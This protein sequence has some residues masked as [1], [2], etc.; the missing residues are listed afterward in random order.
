MTDLLD[1]PP[2]AGERPR[3]DP[4]IAQ[5][6]I[7]ARREEGRRRLQ[8]VLVAAAVVAC[9]GLAFGSLYTPL[10]QV[11]HVRITV[12][13]GSFP[14]RTVSRLSG[15]TSRTPTLDVDSR[16]VAARLDA[17]PSLGAARVAR[18]W[19]GTV[20]I[21]VVVRSPLAVVASRSGY[22][23]V[24]PT[25]R[26]L[27]VVGTQ[28]AGLPVLQGSFPV[29]T[30]GGW[31]VGSSGPAAAP[32]AAAGALV[33]MT[34]DS[35]GTDVPSGPAAALAFIEALPPVLRTDVASITVAQGSLT[36]VV[37]PPRVATGTVTVLLGDGSQLQAKV[38]ALVTLLDQGDLSGVGGV[39]LTVPSRPATASTVAGLAPARPATASQ[40]GSGSAQ[41]SMAGPDSATT[42]GSGAAAGGST[43]AA[44]GAGAANG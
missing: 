6:W 24:D 22:A 8:V 41:S 10:F 20:M 16:A 44:V 1:R 9:A 17:D 30:P 29:P 18:H 38:N 36:L 32:G 23:D 14:V 43:T 25:G 11:R 31:L 33:D 15:V 4:R 42:T 26:V 40:A 21:G 5:R 2:V 27:A 34:A 28:P 37:N 35:D 19:P 7:D 13:G 39:D 3:I 12:D